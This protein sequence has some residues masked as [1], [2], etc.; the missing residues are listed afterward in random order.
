MYYESFFFPLSFFFRFHFCPWKPRSLPADGLHVSVKNEN[1]WA[2]ARSTRW[3]FQTLRICGLLHWMLKTKTW[4]EL[5]LGS[6]RRAACGL[7][8]SRVQSG[9]FCVFKKNKYLCWRSVFVVMT[10]RGSNDRR[11]LQSVWVSNRFCNDIIQTKS[12]GWNT[13]L[14]CLCG[15]LVLH[16]VE[17][18]SLFKH[19][20]RQ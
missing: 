15:Q 17:A 6:R 16:H 12:L 20:D 4:H 18:K 7:C 8:V 13:Q 3:F 10:P 9:G 1:C 19:P 11:R 5:E 2:Q 14:S